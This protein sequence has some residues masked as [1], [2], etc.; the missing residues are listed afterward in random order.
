MESA[1]GI[2]MRSLIRKESEE[3]TIVEVGKPVNQ[4][5]KLLV[6]QIICVAICI[7]HV[8]FKSFF[9][10]EASTCVCLWVLMYC[11]YYS[12]QSRTLKYSYGYARALPTGNFIC[13]LFLLTTCIG[14][15]YFIFYLKIDIDSFLFHSILAVC[16]IAQL[17]LFKP[18]VMI[19]ICI[20]WSFLK[21]LISISLSHISSYFIIIPDIT[22][23]IY[24][25]ISILKTCKE[26]MEST[27]NDDKY[28]EVCQVLRTVNII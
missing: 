25:S 11:E 19:F 6:L 10:I 2:Q 8:Y 3:R 24:A 13:Y 9:L 26:L 21:H 23:L 16:D 12:A 17:F 28:Y 5:S 27:L 20:L 4:Q 1:T 15:C 14:D 22:V 18:P 7:A